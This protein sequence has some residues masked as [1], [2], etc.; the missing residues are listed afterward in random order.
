MSKNKET[1]KLS[2]KQIEKIIAGQKKI[3]IIFP[4]S[5]DN[6][7][8]EILVTPCIS[9]ENK[10]Q[11]IADVVNGCFVEN[12]YQP[13]YR[14]ELFKIAVLEYF[15]NINVDTDV[16]ILYAIVSDTNIAGLVINILHD[17]GIAL[18]DMKQV[19]NDMIEYRKQEILYSYKKEFEEMEQVL[20]T[21]VAKLEEYI[22]MF[23]SIGEQFKDINPDELMSVLNHFSEKDEH[24]LVETILSTQSDKITQVDGQLKLDV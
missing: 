19:I 13:Y 18:T 9:K 20:E 14:D 24:R 23:S 10:A 3:P 2:V 1:Q 16:S 8:I 6:D 11:F 17:N 21:S 5:M 7:V 15:T 12:A 4:C 22:H